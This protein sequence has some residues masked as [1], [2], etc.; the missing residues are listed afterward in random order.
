[1]RR[2]ENPKRR[3]VGIFWWLFLATIALVVLPVS[4]FVFCDVRAA[5]NLA[6]EESLRYM[7]D[8]AHSMSR[9]I[10]IAVSRRKE[11]I[12]TL[13]DIKEKAE[14]ASLELVKKVNELETFNRLAVGREM[15]MV[16]LKRQMNKLSEKCGEKPLYNVSPVPDGN[17]GK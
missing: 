13:A 11:A 2:T 3:G 15:M 16:E 4:V 14:A 8:S 5:R 7:R 17:D 9:K 6:T 1:M 12:R 10:D